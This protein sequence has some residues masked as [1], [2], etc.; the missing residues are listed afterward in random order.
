MNSYALASGSATVSS[1]TTTTTTRAGNTGTSVV[2]QGVSGAPHMV[3][4]KRLNAL[5][6]QGSTSQIRSIQELLEVLDTESGPEEVLTFPKPHFIPVY[7]TNA[8]DVATVL[9][10]L[11]VHRLETG[12][13]QANHN[14]AVVE[15]FHSVDSSA[16][17]AVQVVRQVPTPQ[18]NHHRHR[19]LAQNDN[20][21]RCRE[22]LV[23]VS[24]VGPLLKEVEAVVREIDVRAESKPPESVSVVTLKRT[25]PSAV[26]Q[27]LTAC[28][29]IKYKFPEQ[30][31]ITCPA[32]TATTMPRLA[33]VTV[34]SGTVASETVA[35]ATVVSGMAFREWRFREWRFREWRFQQRG[36][37]GR[38]RESGFGG[39]ITGGVTD[40]KAV[41]IAGR[42]DN[43]E[44]MVAAGVVGEART[45]MKGAIRS[46][47]LFCCCMVMATS[48]AYAQRGEGRFGGR[49]GGGKMA[50]TTS[51]VAC[52]N[53]ST[54]TGMDWS[55]RTKFPSKRGG[56]SISHRPKRRRSGGPTHSCLPRAASPHA[57]GTSSSNTNSNGNASDPYPR[58]P[59]FCETSVRGFGVSPETLNGKVVDLEKNTTVAFWS[60]SIARLN[61][62]TRTKRPA[63]T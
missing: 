34:A 43:A 5:F 31:T 21:R 22:Q 6:V 14:G 3:A 54:P 11:Y 35:L 45:T 46:I 55:K 59:L 63:G 32:T 37:P 17:G 26:Q 38:W 49:G 48:T 44:I 50:V 13:D 9:K 19:S 2:S 1:A 56:L 52:C 12:Q 10:E 20:R 28:W 18:R 42:V 60:R 51:A 25:H 61:A 36:F 58:V 23:V 7:Y 24:A 57:S 27:A 41:A 40:G 62:T 53:D 30:P 8:Q 39:G 15:V 16:D 29:V 4:D 47:G 33:H